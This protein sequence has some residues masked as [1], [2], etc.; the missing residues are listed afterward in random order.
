MCQRLNIPRKTYLPEIGSLIIYHY[1]RFI[2][3]KLSAYLPT[4]RQTLVEAGVTELL[5]TCDDQN[6]LQAGIPLDGTLRAINLQED[7]QGHI[8]ALRIH[9]PNRPVLVAEYWTGWFDWWGD[10]ELIGSIF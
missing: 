10:K 3:F 1:P 4:L 2:R 6:G 9:Q 5:F 8:S 7:P